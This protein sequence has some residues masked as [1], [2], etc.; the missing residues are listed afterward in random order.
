MSGK[1]SKVQSNTRMPADGFKRPSS[2]CK[3]VNSASTRKRA[4]SASTKENTD[5]NFQKSVP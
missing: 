1:Y 2:P 4:F 3:N 5:T